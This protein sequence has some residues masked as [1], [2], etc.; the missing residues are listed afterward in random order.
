[1]RTTLSLDDDVFAVARQRAQRERTSLGEA[2]SR[3][4]RDALR[5][6]AH[7]P[8]A[9]AALRSKYSVLPARD[10]IITTEHVRRLMDQEGI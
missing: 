1:M 8:A 7:A 10:E 4:V 3:Y 5:A 6:N 9:S 2:V